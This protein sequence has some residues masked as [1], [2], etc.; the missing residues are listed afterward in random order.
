MRLSLLI[1]T[2]AFSLLSCSIQKVKRSSRSLITK[3]PDTKCSIPFHEEDGHMF[4]DVNLQDSNYVFLFDTGW[5]ITSFSENIALK[6]FRT[7][8]KTIL[9]G[10]TVE[11]QLIDFGE[12]EE[13]CLDSLKFQNVLVSQL[14]LD[15]INN[16]KNT[17][18][19][20]VF[21]A[22][23]MSTNY[24]EIDYNEKFIH[25]SKTI[26]PLNT[27]VEIPFLSKGFGRRKINITIN[28]KDVQFVFDTGY[29]GSILLNEK[30]FNNILLAEKR[31]SFEMAGIDYGALPYKVETG[32][33]NLIGYEFLKKYKIVFNFEKDL[34][35]L[36]PISK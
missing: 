7:K 16:N 10:S 18:V 14:N 32:V 36:K 25:V 5:D 2:V 34:L 12:V 30:T 8:F 4:V 11:T 26:G 17:K 31:L 9:S 22:N 20:G 24:W 35:Y 19:T 33:A 28:G 21:G 6:S 27:F 23:L 1:I 29:N 13:V 15:F 3:V